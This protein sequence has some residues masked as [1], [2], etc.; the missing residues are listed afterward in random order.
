MVA[1]AQSSKRHSFK[2]DPK[3][4]LKNGNETWREVSQE[5]FIQAE[6]EAGFHPK[7]GCCPVATNGFFKGAAKGAVTYGDNHPDTPPSQI[8]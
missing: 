2:S 5:R 3:Y 4:W 6:R 8:K 7:V 1:L